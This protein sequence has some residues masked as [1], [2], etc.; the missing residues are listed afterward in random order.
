M[1]WASVRDNVRL[2]LKL[3]RM[4]RGEADGAHR[5]GAGAGRARRIRR[6]LS[7]RI[8]RRHEDAGLAGARAGHRSRNPAD[9][10]AVRRARRDHALPA[11]QRSAGAVAQ[12]AQDR[13]LRHPFGV[14][15][16]LSVAAGGRDDGAARAHRRASFASTR[17]SR[18]ARSFAPR[19]NMP[20]YCREVSNALA[21]SYAGQRQA[22]EAPCQEQSRRML[23]P[24]ARARGR[25]CAVGARGA[26]QRYPALCAAGAVAVFQ[27]L[28]SDWPVLSESLGV[29]LLT[30]LEGFIAAAVGGIALALLFNQSKWLEYS[31]FPYA[32][33]LQV[34]PVIAIAPLLADLSAAADRGGRLRLDRRVLSGAVQH[35]ARAEFGRPQ[36]GRPVPALRRVAAADAALPQ[37]AGGAA[38]YSRRPADR[39]RPVADRRRGR[40]D[41]GRLG[42]RRL[43]ASPTGSPNPAIASTFPG[44]SPRCCCSRPPGLSSMG[45]WR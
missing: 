39:G 17:R 28:V 42:G 20:A 21:P 33:I 34:T 12:P 22:H 5:R 19:P 26:R 41:R 30:T 29:T 45:C 36:S 4:C 13:H 7:A 35:H 14:R 37:I 32:V 24:V 10:R 18:A 27:T 44:C 8:V 31:L 25:P 11:Q 1:P 16:G 6:R 9:G 43:R 40:R 3:A 2:P 38:V 15:V 23:L